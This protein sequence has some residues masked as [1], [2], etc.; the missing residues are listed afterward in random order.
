MLELK[1]QGDD[2]VIACVFATNAKEVARFYNP[3]GHMAPV[4]QASNN[5]ISNQIIS[6]SNG[7]LTCSFTRA[8]ALSESSFFDLNSQHFLLVAAGATNDAGKV[9]TVFVAMK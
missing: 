1:T 6:L 2:D 9:E 7:K 3:S 5:G 4:R 8:I